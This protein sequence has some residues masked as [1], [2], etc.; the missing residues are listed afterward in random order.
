MEISVTAG[1]T[2][3]FKHPV[4]PCSVVAIPGSGGTAKVE[5]TLS[6]IAAVGAGSATWVEWDD[7]AVSDT[8]GTALYSPVTA[9][10]FTATTEDAVFLVHQYA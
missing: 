5:Y 4:I 9:L 10:R 2:A 8:T 7:G 3:T 1:S 6:S